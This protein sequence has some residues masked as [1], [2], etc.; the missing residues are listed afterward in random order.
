MCQD[1]AFVS[2]I[3]KCLLITRA[4]YLAAITTLNEREIKYDNAVTLILGVVTIE[5]LI[6]TN[7]IALTFVILYPYIHMKMYTFKRQ[8]S[9][10]I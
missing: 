8:P 3:L 2:L 5:Q 6:L 4:T 7:I 10:Y 9:Y 1:Q